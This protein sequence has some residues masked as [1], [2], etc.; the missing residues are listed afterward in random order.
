MEEQEEVGRE[1]DQDVRS[2]LNGQDRM[3]R[4][5]DSWLEIFSREGDLRL[6]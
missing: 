1:V 3:E 4:C 2:R 6:W 5:R